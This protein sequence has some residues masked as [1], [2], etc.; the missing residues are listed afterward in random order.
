M[1]DDDDDTQVYQIQQLYTQGWND[2]LEKA[3]ER[4]E[5]ITAFG[6]TTQESFAVFIKGLKK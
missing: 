3:A 6:K 1:D 5:E 4:I 2:A